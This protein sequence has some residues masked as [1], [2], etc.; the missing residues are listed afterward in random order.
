MNFKSNFE[1]NNKYI[2]DFSLYKYRIKSYLLS[3]YN[4]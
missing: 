4:Y 1:K 3:S 2:I